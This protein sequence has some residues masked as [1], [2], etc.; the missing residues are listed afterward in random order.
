MADTGFAI[1]LNRG[2]RVSFENGWTASVQFGTGNYC[3]R[4]DFDAAFDSELGQEM[5]ESK[6]AEIAAF[7]TN[8]EGDWFKLSDH[9]DVKGWVKP[10]EIPDFLS[11][12]QKFEKRN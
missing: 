11:M 9:D 3:E 12:V 7:P 4:R 5:V 6:N 1:T 10:D 8:G 2:F